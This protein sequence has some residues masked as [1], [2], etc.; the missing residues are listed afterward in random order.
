MDEALD[1]GEKVVVFTQYLEMIDLITAW[2]DEYG[3][4]W[5]SLRGDTKNRRAVVKAFQTDPECR[6]F[7]GSLLAGGLGI[8]LTAGSVVIHYDRWWN[9]ARENQATDRVHRIG[10]T[11]GVQ[12]IKLITRGT[13]EEKIDQ[14][15]RK[16]AELLDALVEDDAATL[17]ALSREELIDILTTSPVDGER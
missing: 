8:D 15:I 6:V 14:M 2:L 17:K 13:L 10:Q 9:A 16:K 5:V 7:V 3:A 1:G 11:R 4:R 12:V